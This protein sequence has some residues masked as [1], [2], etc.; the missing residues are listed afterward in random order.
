MRARR[1]ADEVAAAVGVAAEPKDELLPG[2][3]LASLRRA[4]VG[5][6]G[7]VAIVGHQPDCSEI[8]LAVTGADPGFAPGAM[9]ELELSE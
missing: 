7:P 2:A 8:A 1:T 6:A 5:V 4:L 3:S 9:T